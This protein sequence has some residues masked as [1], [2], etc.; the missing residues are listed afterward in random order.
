MKA[1]FAFHSQQPNRFFCNLRLWGALTQQNRS[2]SNEKISS[3]IIKLSGLKAQ[4]DYYQAIEKITGIGERGPTAE[5][6][7]S[8][9]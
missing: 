5:V 6:V 1:F 3:G 9:N 8:R 2:A 4:T 7:P